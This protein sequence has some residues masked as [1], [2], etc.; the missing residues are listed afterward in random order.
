[1][2]EKRLLCFTIIMLVLQFGN[3]FILNS[4]SVNSGNIYLDSFIMEEKSFIV[5][6]YLCK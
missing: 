3:Y 5:E 1:M 4:I 6:H 2:N